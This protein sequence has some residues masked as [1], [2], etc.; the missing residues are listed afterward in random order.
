MNRLSI[1]D[2]YFDFLLRIG[3]KGPFEYNYVREVHTEYVKGNIIV[4]II[5]E[6][7][8]WVFVSKTKK[9]IPELELGTK[10]I[11][12]LTYFEYKSYNLFDLDPKRRLYKSVY[13][14]NSDEKDLWF[15]SRLLQ[16]NPEILDGNF[17]KFNSIYYLLKKIGLIK[18]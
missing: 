8:F 18:H 3:F 12:D 13:F 10:K 6:G 5:Y 9:T 7:S 14:N 2:K 11:K 15:F 16:D 1:S 17:K 4:E